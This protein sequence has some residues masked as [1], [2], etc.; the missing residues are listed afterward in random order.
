MHLVDENFL[1]GD[2]KSK[3]NIRRGA[4][5]NKI[6]KIKFYGLVLFGEFAELF[7]HLTKCQVAFLP[8]LSFNAIEVDF[9]SH[10]ARVGGISTSCAL[11]P[12]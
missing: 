1:C 5:S 4:N 12:M 9:A 8:T 3:K 7:T 10:P 2:F 11:E 6:K